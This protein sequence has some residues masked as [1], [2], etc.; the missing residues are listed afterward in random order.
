MIYYV[1]S[2]Y[3]QYC[4]HIKCTCVNV[5]YTHSMHS[6]GDAGTCHAQMKA[7]AHCRTT[8]TEVIA[9]SF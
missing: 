6:L 1:V 3:Q 4:S 8:H 5:A 2:A 9:S 7:D